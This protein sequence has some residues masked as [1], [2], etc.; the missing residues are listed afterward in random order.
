M[1]KFWRKREA[2]RP[3]GDPE[4]AREKLKLIL[5]VGPHKTGTTS[6]QRALL[7]QYGSKKPQA[8][9]YPTPADF[10]PGHAMIGWA[11]LGLRGHAQPQPAIRELI[12]TSLRSDCQVLILSSEIF[13]VAYRVKIAP[14]IEQTSDTDTHIVV[15]LSPIGRRAVSLWQEMVKHR[16]RIPLEHARD[17]VLSRPGLAPGLTGHLAAH[18]P[19]SKI[20]VVIAN[21]T[22]PMDL[23]RLFSEATGLPL[24]IPTAPTELTMNR[25]Q[26]LAE[27]EVIRG[28]NLGL[29]ATDLPDEKYSKA[30]TMLRKLFDSKEWRSA[31]PWV[32]LALPRD[33]IEPLSKQ[34]AETISEL[35]E[36]ESQ[37]RIEIFGDVD[38]LDD[39]T[40]IQ[41][42][43]DRAHGIAFSKAFPRELSAVGRPRGVE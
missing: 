1:L 35:R 2:G 5:H 23:Y 7:R 6:L 40:Q 4:R 22:A 30:R 16:S 29:A 14:L 34:C 13:A 20:S 18:F 31:V 43:T 17:L 21:P 25:G 15:T 26:G 3:N 27:T 32:P 28:L 33:W 9:W 12:E 36:L 37:G 19:A 11:A 41:K 10:G 38:S 8:I 42:Q 24:S 39:L